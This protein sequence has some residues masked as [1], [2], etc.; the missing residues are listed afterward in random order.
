[1]LDFYHTGYVKKKIIKKLKAT[2]KR[3]EREKNPWSQ[4]KDY[5]LLPVI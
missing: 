1:M 4:T 5:F 2:L 3:E